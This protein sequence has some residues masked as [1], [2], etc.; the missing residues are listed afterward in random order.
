MSALAAIRSV[1]GKRVAK[2]MKWGLIPHSAKDDKTQYSTHN[3]RSEEFRTKS[4][5]WDA[6]ERGQRC[7]IITNGFYEWK[8]LDTKGKRKRKQPYANRHVREDPV[9]T[10]HKP[11]SRPRKSRHGRGVDPIA[12]RVRAS[13]QQVRFVT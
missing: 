6:W 7:L 11:T 9:R 4:A 10:W 12:N 8:K 13:H 5:F 1:D 3:A 2:M